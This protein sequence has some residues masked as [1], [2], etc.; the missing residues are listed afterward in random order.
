MGRHAS[1]VDARLDVTDAYAIR[2]IGIG[3]GI[4]CFDPLLVVYDSVGEVVVPVRQ[5]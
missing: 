5:Q 1:R 3:T 4:W 2:Y